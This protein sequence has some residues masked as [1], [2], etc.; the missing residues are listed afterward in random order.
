MSILR[1]LN[2]ISLFIYLV[3]NDLT[4]IWFTLRVNFFWFTFDMMRIVADGLTANS[5]HTHPTFQSRNGQ[6]IVADGLTA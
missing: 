6:R 2:N 4:I 5:I 3:F 1:A